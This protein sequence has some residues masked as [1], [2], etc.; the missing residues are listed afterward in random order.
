MPMKQRLRLAFTDFWEG[1]DCNPTGKSHFDNVLYRI[2]AER[3][4]IEISDNPEF[5]IYSVFGSNHK[6]FTCAS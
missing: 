6:R 5:L 4:D 2:L 3:F 1:F